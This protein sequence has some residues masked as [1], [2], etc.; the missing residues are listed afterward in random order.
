MLCTIQVIL[1]SNVLYY[2]GERD[3]RFRSWRTETGPER[4]L[5][6]QHREGESFNIC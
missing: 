1:C 6:L 3:T 4:F 2:T 5:P